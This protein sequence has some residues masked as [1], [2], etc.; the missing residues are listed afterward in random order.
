MTTCSPTSPVSLWRWL[1]RIIDFPLFCLTEPVFYFK[2]D[3][4]LCELWMKRLYEICAAQTSVTC[5]QQVY[6]EQC[7]IRLRG[8]ENTTLS[9]PPGIKCT[10]LIK[11]RAS[12]LLTLRFS[13]LSPATVSWCDGMLVKQDYSNLHAYFPLYLPQQCIVY[14]VDT[15]GTVTDASTCTDVINF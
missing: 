3:T 7:V 10:F 14:N 4:L 15:R 13:P 2:G 8:R 1:D 11:P 9:V 12:C 6:S 5:P